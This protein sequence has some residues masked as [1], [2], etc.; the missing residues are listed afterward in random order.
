[1]PMIENVK[2]KL[3]KNIIDSISKIEKGYGTLEDAKKIELM[4]F[5]LKTLPRTEKTYDEWFATYLQ[6]IH[7]EIRYASIIPHLLN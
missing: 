3:I 6:I 2:T 4:L 1:M 7:L 5:E